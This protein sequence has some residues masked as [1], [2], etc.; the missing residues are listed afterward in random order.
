MYEGPGA[1]NVFQLLGD[2]AVFNQFADVVDFALEKSGLLGTIQ[3]VGFHPNHRFAGLAVED[4]VNAVNRA[5]FPMLHL[6]REASIE[7]AIR[8]HPDTAG[9]PERNSA[10]LRQLGWAEVEVRL[11]GRR[12]A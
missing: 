2:F 6:L 3:V 9:I 12:P 1:L 8:T 4:V 11:R 7:R 10:L 5:P